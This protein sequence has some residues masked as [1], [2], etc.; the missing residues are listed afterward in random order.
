MARYPDVF[1]RCDV[2]CHRSHNI[3]G[4]ICMLCRVLSPQPQHTRMYTYVVTCVVT[5][6]SPQPQHTRMYTYVVTC[7]VTAATTYPDV[8]VCCDVCCDT[9]VTAAT[10]YP[11]VYVCCAV[12]CDRS[13]HLT[14]VVK[15]HREREA[16][17]MQDL[18]Q[19][20]ATHIE[21]VGSRR[22][23]RGTMAAVG[24]LLLSV[25]S[26]VRL[27]LVTVIFYSFL[28]SLFSHNSL[29]LLQSLAVV[30]HSPPIL[31]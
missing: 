16:K 30:L 28:S 6:L 13:H 24:L 2:C 8:Y 17:M 3:P 9:V 5:L 11:D 21:K 10:T 25:S 1:I 15:E 12:C 29:Q 22:L 20:L 14:K 4:C 26:G 18:N 7:V 23:A 31:S 27:T 19:R